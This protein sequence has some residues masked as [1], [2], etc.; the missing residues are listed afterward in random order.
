MRI[1]RYILLLMAACLIAASAP[2]GMETATLQNIRQIN[3]DGFGKDSNKYA[4]SMAVFQGSLFVGTLNMKD[5]ADMSRFFSGT[6][7]RGASEGAEI[8]RYDADGTWTQ[9]VE[10]GLGNPHNIGV[11]KMMVAKGCIFGVTANHNDGME[12]W[13]SCDGENWTRAAQRGFGDPDNTSGRGLGVYKDYIYAGTEN[14]S[15]GA[16]LWRSKDGET[17]TQVV[18]HGISD[19][20]NWWFSDFMIFKDHLYMGTL[21]PWGMQLFRTGDGL[22]FERLFKGGMDKFTNTAAMKLYTFQDT[23]YLTT[24]DYFRGYDLYSSTDGVNFQRV[25][26]QGLPSD[27]HAYLWQLIEYKGRLYGGTYYHRGLRLPKGSFALLSTED[28][29]HWKIENQDGFGNPWHYGI[30][31]VAVYNGELIM[32]AASAKYGCKVFAAEAK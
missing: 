13:R 19:R 15:K 21:N 27:D 30:R 2:S 7:T 24:M 10:K 8:W 12:V 1:G 11:R 6:S 16:Q 28:G 23:L 9:V 26:K 29:E 17:W 5:M 18:K 32:G 3:Q 20:N 4:F 31:S 22:H 14:R 25:I